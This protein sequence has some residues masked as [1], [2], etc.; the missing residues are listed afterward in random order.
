[1]Q[2]STILLHLRHLHPHVEI[3]A[4]VSSPGGRHRLFEGLCHRSFGP[5]DSLPDESHYDAMHDV[6]M[7]EPE[8][9]FTYH[10]ASKPEHMLRY[11]FGITPLAL[12]CRYELS[13][14]LEHLERARDCLNRLSGAD[15]R[16]V[17]IQY[18]GDSHKSFK[19]INEQVI[20]KTCKAIAA[21]GW[22][23]L[24]LDPGNRSSLGR[25][26]PAVLLRGN[27]PF[28]GNDPGKWDAAKTFALAE[29][30]DLRIG[31]DSG[32]G[33]LFG[34]TRV[35]QT[36]APP[37]LIVWPRTTQL[38][39]LHYYG[40]ANHVTHLVKP[41][42]WRGIRGDWGVGQT[43]FHNAYRHRVAHQNLRY[44]L[45]E[46]VGRMIAG[47]DV[48]DRHSQDG[49]RNTRIGHVR[50]AQIG[51]DHRVLVE[52]LEHDDLQLSELPDFPSPVW[53]DV[54]SHIGAATLA[55][56]K[57]W[58]RFGSSICVDI[59]EESFN[60]LARNV[61]DFSNVLRA[62]ISY[63]KGRIE[64]AE[65]Q[66]T[67]SLN[68]LATPGEKHPIEVREA[69]WGRAWKRKPFDCPQFTLE[70]LMRKFG[71]D[72]IDVLKLDCEGSERGIFEQAVCL[73][74]IGIIV[75]EWHGNGWFRELVRDRLEPMGF[76]LVILKDWEDLG[77]FQLWNRPYLQ[78]LGLPDRSRALN[79]ATN[80]A[81]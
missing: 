78:E 2:F 11:L 15:S 12:L 77:L 33:H 79:L 36:T 19:D 18:Q 24:I 25:C 63:H 7:L 5:F 81:A 44:E 56:R 27:D 16:T 6:P 23:P 30:C 38:H 1:M 74:R 37:T 55:A 54:G 52:Q 68:L 61:G 60:C 57:K 39:P 29:L 35:G 22:T 9:S 49:I 4:I 28:W 43:Y 34:A 50:H 76:G 73:D 51:H 10:P 45:P 70:G 46:V 13:A 67:S 8:S 75:G 20:A 58:G 26:I 59:A 64:I 3:D 17:L 69:N 32:P 72:R 53:V 80:S 48:S 21:A 14:P 47:E 41:D 31:I 71:L 42:H 40:L 66:D 65:C 62:A